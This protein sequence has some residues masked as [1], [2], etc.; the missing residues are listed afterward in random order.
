MNARVYTSIS[1]S[2]ILG[3][4]QQRAARSWMCAGI[5]YTTI[6]A[7]SER[8]TAPDGAQ[9]LIAERDGSK[10]YGKPYIFVDDLLTQAKA[11]D[12]DVAIITNSDI[13]LVSNITKHLQLAANHMVISRRIEY[14]KTPSDGKVYPYGVDLFMLPRR[15]LDLWP[16]SQFVLGQTWWDYWLPYWAMKHKERVLMPRVPV[17]AH[18]AHKIQH[19]PEQW[20]R[21]TC[22][23]QFLTGYKPL[24]PAQETGTAIHHYIERNV[25]M[26]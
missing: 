12:V 21:Q 11:D 25:A 18:K 16:S 8:I 26:F 15:M 6:N 10:L 1:P 14:K 4:V 13:E 9:C 24:R 19:S 23:F 2:H 5:P 17:I 3:D 20:H 7:Q 22:L